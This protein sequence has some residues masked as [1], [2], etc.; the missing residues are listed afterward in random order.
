MGYKLEACSCQ[1]QIKQTA[2]RRTRETQEP[3]MQKKQPTSATVGAA[4]FGCFSS[5]RAEAAAAAAARLA[6]AAE[7]IPP[8]EK[9]QHDDKECEKCKVEKQFKMDNAKYF[10]SVLYPFILE[11]SQSGGD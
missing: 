1:Q 7:R 8:S 3:T 10:S 9:K 2:E 11:K 4:K 6:A 5:T